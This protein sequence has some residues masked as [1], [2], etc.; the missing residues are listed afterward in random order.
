MTLHV[1]VVD[2]EPGFDALADVW[3]A[4]SERGAGDPLFS[5]YLWNRTWWKHYRHLGELRLVVAEDDDAVVGIW[6]LFLARRTF[7]EVEV[8]MIGPR[9]MALPGG[10]K[11]RV[12]AYLGSGEICSDFVQ[13]LVEPGR[14]NEIV[15]AMLEHLAVQKDFDL[16]DLCDLD[17]DAPTT[18]AIRQ[19]LQKH[20]GPMRERFRYKAPY[21]ELPGSYD[22]YLATL[23][24]KGRYNA[25]KKLRQLQTNQKVEHAHHD[26]PATLDDAMTQFMD[27]HRQRWEAEGL[28]GVFVNEHFV[29]FHRELAREALARNWLRLGFLRVNDETLFCTYAFDVNGR[30]YLYQQGG[31]TDWHHYNLGY[32][33]LGF[34]VA[35]ACEREAKVYDFLR[36]DAEYKLHWAKQH[37]VLI[38]LQAVRKNLRGRMFMWHSKLNTDDALRQRVKR[39]LGRK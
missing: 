9:K 3:V 34:S 16:L 33:A 32:V 38:Q 5:S 15:D 31:M 1:R 14:E 39:L 11:V 36:G 24:K 13:P 29:G 22:D 25:R 26:D 21:A 20:F 30:V 8:D 4:L 27:M 10:T 37:R 35:D 17:A 12:L 2:D 7:R 6:P 23:S 28:P 18:E 19:G